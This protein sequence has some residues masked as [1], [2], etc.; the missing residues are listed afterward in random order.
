MT[1]AWLAAAPSGAHLRSVHL[2]YD[3]ANMAA[4]QWPPPPALPLQFV[5]AL[6]GSASTLVELHDLPLIEPA[7]DQRAVGL[8]AFTR[9]RVLTL[10]QARAMGTLHAALLPAS[11]VDLTLQLNL[12]DME[13]SVGM[14]PPLFA[15]FDR[16]HHLRCITLVGF[17]S[18]GLASPGGRR[19]QQRPALFPRRL[20]VRA[21]ALARQ[22]ILLLLVAQ[23]LFRTHATLWSAHWFKLSAA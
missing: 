4:G 1:P 15:N 16:L 5:S 7:S 12:P 17:A 19:G 18:W 6:A 8:T 21:P 23:L 9:L 10:R 2:P 11:L 3:P 14:N 22:L 20:K 13:R